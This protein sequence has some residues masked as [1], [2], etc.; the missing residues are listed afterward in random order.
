ML[1]GADN[2]CVFLLILDANSRPQRRNSRLRQNPSMQAVS[3]YWYRSYFKNWPLNYAQQKK[4]ANRRPP[5][6]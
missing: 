1:T 4:G 3:Y 2:G 5:Y 6:P